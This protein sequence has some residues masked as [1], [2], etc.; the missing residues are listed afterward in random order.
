M[1]Y[2]SDANFNS[3]FVHFIL[4]FVMCIYN[5]KLK[6]FTAVNDSIRENYTLKEPEY[7]QNCMPCSAII[8]ELSNQ[9]VGCLYA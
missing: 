8:V 7:D 6:L 1:D 9:K 3:T 5:N 4:Y 2:V